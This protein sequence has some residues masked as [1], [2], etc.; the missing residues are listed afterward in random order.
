MSNKRVLDLMIGLTDFPL[1]SDSD[2]LKKALDSMTKFRLGFV[3]IVNKSGQLVGVLT[4]GDLRR[5]LLTKQNPLPALL[6]NKA[7]EFSQGNPVSVN[8]S[9]LIHDCL[10][11]MKKNKVSD[12]PVITDENEL[13]GI[14]HFHDLILFE[15]K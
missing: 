7:L 15:P 4:D 12:L 6:I 1:I 5:L 3:C 13:I 14:V 10:A 8:S 9:A 11:V 2:S